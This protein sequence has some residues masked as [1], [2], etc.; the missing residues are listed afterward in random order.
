MPS[1]P[2]TRA[3]PGRRGSGLGEDWQAVTAGLI[4]PRRCGGIV[5]NITIKATNAKREAAQ[6]TGFWTEV[7]GALAQDRE[8]ADMTHHPG[9]VAQLGDAGTVLRLLVDAFGQDP[10]WG[11]WAFP[12]PHGRRDQRQAVFGVLVDGALR[13]PWVWLSAD[14]TAAAVWIPPGGSEMSA[15]QAAAWQPLLQQVLGPDAARV[16]RG[17]ELFESARPA[18][19]HYY[20]T[21]FG[22]DP[23]HAG[24]GYGRRLLAA[25]LRLID[26]QGA[27]AY[28][29]SRTALVPFYMRHGFRV[30][31]TFDLPDGPTVNC[32]WRPPGS[33]GLSQD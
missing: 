9:R 6:P 16:I 13:Y 21:L 7:A 19:P 22:T 12:D 28:L 4:W 31:N 3:G 25:N 11:Q 14:D 32:M 15:E 30:V 2:T 33:G 1:L 29:E 18:E 27:A 17:F 20:L 5:G 26:D 23:S 24:H 8:T 10:M